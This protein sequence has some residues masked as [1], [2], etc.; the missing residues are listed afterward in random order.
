MIWKKTEVDEAAAQPVSPPQAPPAPSLR[1]PQSGREAA[2]IG[3]SIEL[4][5]EIAGGEDLLVEGKIEGRIE[6][7]KYNVTIGKS[8]QVRADIYGGTIVVMGEVQGN[9]YAEEK[10]V[11]RQTSTVKGNLL[12]PRVTLEDGSNFKGSIDMTAGAAEAATQSASAPRPAA[13][14]ALPREQVA[15]KV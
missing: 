1:G 5:G 3:P 7:N 13:P 4:K 12:A 8:G 15:D 6:L 14:L 2:L 9:L 10:I 11:L